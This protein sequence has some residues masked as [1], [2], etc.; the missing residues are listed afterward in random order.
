MHMARL[1]I[2]IGGKCVKWYLTIISR[3]DWHDKT[4]QCDWHGTRHN[5]SNNT[6]N[7]STYSFTTVT[8]LFANRNVE[9]FCIMC[10]VNTTWISKQIIASFV[11]NY[12]TVCCKLSCQFEWIVQNG[13]RTFIRH[14]LCLNIKC[15]LHIVE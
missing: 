2:W 5:T 3:C 1:T 14:I 9:L 11:V 6:P 4:P 7:L 13:T 10:E 12:L 8:D 15:Y